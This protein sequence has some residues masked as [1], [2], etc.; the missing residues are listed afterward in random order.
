[1]VEIEQY[2]RGYI[3]GAKAERIASNSYARVKT[4]RIWEM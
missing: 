4:G 2:K 3:V 1:M